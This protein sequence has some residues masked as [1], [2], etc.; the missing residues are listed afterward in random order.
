MITTDE[1]NTVEETLTDKIKKITDGLFYMSED[2]AEIF[3]FVGDKVETITTKDI[4]KANNSPDKTRTEVKD[5]DEFFNN[6]TQIQDWYGDEEKATAAKFTELKEL[7][8]SDL[9][10]LK[11]YKIGKKNVDIYV[12]GLN[13]E[14]IITGIKTK[15]VET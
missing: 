14:N 12:V 11:V 3:P 9:K 5:F 13:A 7:L 6:L 4:L 15:A 1:K 2:D 10:E 8:E